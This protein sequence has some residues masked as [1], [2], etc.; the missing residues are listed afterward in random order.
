MTYGIAVVSLVAMHHQVRWQNIKQTCCGCTVSNLSANEHQTQ[1]T[2]Q[3]ITQ[4]MDLHG[5]STKRAANC[6]AGFQFFHHLHGGGSQPKNCRSAPPNVSHPPLQ[7]R[8]RG[9]HR[10]PLQPNGPSDCTGSSWGHSPMAHQPS[11]LLSS[12][13]ARC[14]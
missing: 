6:V 5:G 4:G 7:G 3:T 2:S 1:R 11:G 12:A 9:L 10:Y 14:R 8:G 13:H